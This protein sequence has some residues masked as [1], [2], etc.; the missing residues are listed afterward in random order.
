[1]ARDDSRKVFFF[2]VFYEFCFF[3]V[4]PDIL[5]TYRAKRVP[6]RDCC[7]QFALGQFFQSIWRE[8]SKIQAAVFGFGY[9][10][11]R[12]CVVFAVTANPE[13]SKKNISIFEPMVLPTR[14]RILLTNQTQFRRKCNHRLHLWRELT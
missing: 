11:P 3:F 9:R 14:A 10:R 8:L 2:F 13:Y 5:E 1:M 4:I 6:K 7:L 12:H